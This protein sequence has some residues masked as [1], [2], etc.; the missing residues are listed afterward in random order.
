VLTLLL[1]FTITVATS[2]K[3][4]ETDVGGTASPPTWSRTVER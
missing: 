3:M 4:E 1:F 2:R